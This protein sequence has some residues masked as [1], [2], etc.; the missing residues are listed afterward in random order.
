MDT[1]QV[2]QDD[3][4]WREEDTNWIFFS[5]FLVAQH[6]YYSLFVQSGIIPDL[7]TVGWNVRRHHGVI[8]KRE[9]LEAWMEQFKF[10]N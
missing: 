2:E 5:P 1:Q 10:I 3:E 8:I 6:V 4:D 9:D 7:N